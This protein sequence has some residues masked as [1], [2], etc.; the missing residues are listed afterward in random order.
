MFLCGAEQSA[1]KA[2]IAKIENLGFKSWLSVCNAVQSIITVK[3]EF[4]FDG[5]QFAGGA[6][7]LQ[8]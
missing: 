1:P 2:I 4:C 7:N 6:K 8:D 3:L 5:G